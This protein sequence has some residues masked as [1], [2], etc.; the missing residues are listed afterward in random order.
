[1]GE[2]LKVKIHFLKPICIISFVI[3]WEPSSDVG[4]AQIQREI[5]PPGAFEANCII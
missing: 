3:G 5:W 4:Y 2:R 1:M